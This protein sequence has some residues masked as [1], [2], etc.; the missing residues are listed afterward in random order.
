M[1]VPPQ[2]GPTTTPN[3]RPFVAVDDATKAKIQALDLEDGDGSAR[4]QRRGLLAPAAL[5]C[6]FCCTSPPP[7]SL[8][9]I[10]AQGTDCD[11]RLQAL[12]G[13]ASHYRGSGA[14]RHLRQHGRSP[15][16]PAAWSA[17][18]SWTPTRGVLTLAC[19]LPRPAVGTSGL[20]DVRERGRG[21]GGVP[22]EG[23][24]ARAPRGPHLHGRGARAA[25]T[26]GL[27]HPGACV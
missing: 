17:A 2:I 18:P 19:V 27:R 8:L 26:E 16:A 13:A 25:A 20:R 4:W 22:G 9:H 12:A 1:H 3:L 6:R 11:G 24:R 23:R 15:R 14:Q 10:A 5:A 7:V 21:G